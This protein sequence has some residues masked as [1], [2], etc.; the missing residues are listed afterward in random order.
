M[1]IKW[2][3]FNRT[4]YMEWDTLF[5]PDAELFIWNGRQA[6]N[7]Y[8]IYEAAYESELF[9]LFML[10]PIWDAFTLQIAERFAFD[11]EIEESLFKVIVDVS[12]WKGILGS[13]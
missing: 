10:Q 11:E 7:F 3:R 5:L 13:S 2:H 6:P 8:W 12:T 9:E 1:A 4:G